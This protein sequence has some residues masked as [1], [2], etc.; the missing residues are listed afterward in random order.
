MLEK[1]KTY[2][3]TIKERFA[4]IDEI[5]SVFVTKP[6]YEG[7]GFIKPG[8]YEF[9]VTEFNYPLIEG[10]LKEDGEEKKFSCNMKK[11]A[12]HGF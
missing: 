6:R 11:Q 8:K 1:G 3:L 10:I 4:W 2:H 9:Q 12:A 5:D 7:G